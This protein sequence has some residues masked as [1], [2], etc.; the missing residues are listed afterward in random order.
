MAP[1]FFLLVNVDSRTPSIKS[2]FVFC[3]FYSYSFSVG[4]GDGVVDSSESKRDGPPILSDIIVARLY[5]EL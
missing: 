1:R 4:G 2:S 3:T 5:E